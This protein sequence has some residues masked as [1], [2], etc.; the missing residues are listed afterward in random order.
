[1]KP[2]PEDECP[3]CKNGTIG[4]EQG[5]LVCRGECGHDFGTVDTED[6]AIEDQARRAAD[7]E[8]GQEQ[9]EHMGEI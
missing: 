6:D 7:E 3:N 1:M 8:Q 9:P 4:L 5:R 2:T